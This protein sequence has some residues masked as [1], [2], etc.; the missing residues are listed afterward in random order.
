MRTSIVLLALSVI[1]ISCNSHQKDFSNLESIS[2]YDFKGSEIN[3][4]QLKKEWNTTI[5]PIILEDAHYEQNVKELSIKTIRDNSSNEDY[6][7]LVASTSN[8]NVYSGKVIRSFKD[9][10]KLSDKTVTCVNCGPEFQGELVDGDWI[11]AN[12]GESTDGCIKTS[13]LDY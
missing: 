11:C 13:T 3:M 10:F 6:L 1:L 7:V 8:I 9:G 4:D 5:N 12:K 2:F